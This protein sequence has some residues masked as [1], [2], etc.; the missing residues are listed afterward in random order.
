MVQYNPER[1]NDQWIQAALTIEGKIGNWD[2]T[3]PAATCA[4]TTR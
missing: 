2:L 3:L 4:A 1:S